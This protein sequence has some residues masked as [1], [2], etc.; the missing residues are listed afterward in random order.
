MS[1]QEEKQLNEA[2][3]NI[4]IVPGDETPPETRTSKTSVLACRMPVDEIKAVE[5]AAAAVGE[6]VSEY[7]R[8]AI[9]MRREGQVPFQTV[10]SVSIGSPYMQIN[11]S[12]SW[13]RPSGIVESDSY[14]HDIHT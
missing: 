8:K 6:S 12:T 4:S 13:S 11:R 14:P 3:E 7:V 5:K 1:Q 2:N 9:L 10:V